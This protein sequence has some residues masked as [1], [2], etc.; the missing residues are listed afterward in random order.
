M[1]IRP[2]FGTV[3]AELE[4]QAQPAGVTSLPQYTCVHHVD[5]RQMPLKHAFGPQIALKTLKCS[6]RNVQAAE[7]HEGTPSYE[8]PSRKWPLEI[9]ASI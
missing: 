3:L 1:W 7:Q 8:P 5:I 2:S 9:S 4:C 6:V